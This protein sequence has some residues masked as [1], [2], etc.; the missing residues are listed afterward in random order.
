MNRIMMNLVAGGLLALTLTACANAR[1]QDEFYG[2]SQAELDQMLAPVALYPDTVLSHLLIAATYPLEVVQAARWSRQ[3]DGFRGEVAVEAVVDYPWD[4]SVM[5]LVAFPELLDRMD[6]D[7]D[8]T[9]RLGDA[10]LYQE[11]EVL[12]SIQRL[13]AQA[14]HAGHLGSNEH[15][16]VVRERQVIYIEPAR[17]EVIYLPYYQPR[18]VYGRW[19]WADY[20]PVVWHY[21][22]RHR[23]SVVLSWS[24]GY[25]VAPTFFFSSF[26]WPRRHVVVVHHHH[27]YDRPG[28]YPRPWQT[29]DRHFYSGREIARYEGAQRWRHQSEHRRGVAYRSSL[30]ERHRQTA[31]TLR[32]RGVSGNVQTRAHSVTPTETRSQQR[33]WAA[34]RRSE[35]NQTASIP[36]T[37]SRRSGLSETTRSRRTEPL[38]TTPGTER[39]SLRTQAAADRSVPEINRSRVTGSPGSGATSST[40][41]RSST[42]SSRITRQTRDSRP[43][44]STVIQREHRSRTEPTQ[45]PVLRTREAVRSPSAQRVVPERAPVPPRRAESG[46]THSTG[47]IRSGEPRGSSPASQRASVGSRSSSQRAAPEQSIAERTAARRRE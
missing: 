27:H 29:V 43:A 23:S 7:L 16:R 38:T 46:R 40:G 3:N 5:A 18:V 37:Q 33:Q 2:F 26:H 9:Q 39:R 22:R 20:P 45:A 14:H 34:S 35:L 47:V 12:D 10:F 32:T 15:V 17:R 44:S 31:A 41:T 36:N 8:W 19:H 25:R 11:E 13:R 28:H 24:L 21:P 42:Q 4:P 6:N 30:P 1:V